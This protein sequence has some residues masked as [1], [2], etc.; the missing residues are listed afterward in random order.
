MGETVH[1][2]PVIVL[3]SES[4]GVSV[5]GVGLQGGAPEQALVQVSADG[6]R[7]TRWIAECPDFRGLVKYFT[8]LERYWRGW[9]GTKTWSSLEGDLA[10]AATHTG[11]HVDVSVSLESPL[12]W[13]AQAEMSI[14]AGE[15][16]SAARLA[17]A[18]LFDP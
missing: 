5:V 9:R 15:D 6:L 2:E 4:E 16:L 3:G 1:V 17:V 12:T 14:G 8:E 10:F 18:R 11:S 13:K 7:A